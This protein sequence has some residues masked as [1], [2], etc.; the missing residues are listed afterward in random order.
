MR[1]RNRSRA[2]VVGIDDYPG[3]A[4]DLPSCVADGQFMARLLR[5]WYGFSDV[6]ELYDDR[7][8]LDAVS[9]ALG[10]AL[11][12]VT[13]IERV[14]FYFSGHGAQTVRHDELRESICLHD[15]LFHDDALVQASQHLPPN[16]LTVVLDACFAGGMSKGSSRTA[17]IKSRTLIA[18]AAAAKGVV[19][20]S[21]LYR[22]FGVGSRACHGALVG[23]RGELVARKLRDDTGPHLNG[24][25]VSACLENETAAASTPDTD[26]L[27]AFTF[28]LRRALDRLGG[29]ASV[30]V[31]MVE[32]AKGLRAINIVQSPQLHLPD[33]SAM[34]R[35]AL[36]LGAG[37]GPRTTDD[38]RRDGSGGD[39][40][41]NVAQAALAAAIATPA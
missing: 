11:V 39:L 4:H 24:L 15:R 20:L 34:H 6:T 31:L 17:K 38:V 22:P 33:S 5:S 8:S 16:V 12:D 3:A 26:G 23:S 32:V 21:R 30:E 13:P 29:F 27:S 7:A 40:L 2:V 18:R 28:G 36:F 35:F 25:L 37:D 10:A 19:G 41:A 14:V 1:E 9:R